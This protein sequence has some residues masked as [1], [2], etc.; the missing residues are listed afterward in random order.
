MANQHMPDLVAIIKRVIDRQYGPA[1]I[2]EDDLD[3]LLFERVEE[4][5]GAGF[6]ACLFRLARIR[7][8]CCWFRFHERYS[9]GLL[10]PALSHAIKLRNSLP[11]FS[12]G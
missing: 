12:I 7:R 6:L 8:G 11:V 3:A 9:V 4:K 10:A 1:R 5:L 2:A